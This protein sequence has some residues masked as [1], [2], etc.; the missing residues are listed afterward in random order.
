MA[1]ALERLMKWVEEMESESDR[2]ES[3]KLEF[4]E[5]EE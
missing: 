2:E 4:R 1:A 3:E 5:R